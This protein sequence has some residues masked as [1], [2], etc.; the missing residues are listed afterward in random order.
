MADAV[1]LVVDDEA[2]TG[3]WVSR[4]VAGEGHNVTIA[5]RGLAART[6]GGN[7]D[8][9]VFEIELDGANGVELAERMLEEGRLGRVVFFSGATWQKLLRR[10][11]ALGPVIS[12]KSGPVALASEL[13]RIVNS[14]ARDA[15]RRRATGEEK[16][17]A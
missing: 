6:L 13:R 14:R 7:F 12:K 1:F 4:V 15:R 8:V 17:E 5:G 16:L 3:R 10:A 9:G 11:A 2:D